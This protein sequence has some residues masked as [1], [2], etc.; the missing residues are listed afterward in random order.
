MVLVEADHSG[1]NPERAGTAI[2]DEVDPALQLVGGV[3]GVRRT[4]ASGGTTA[5][6]HAMP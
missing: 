2:Q 1:F 5:V 6:V 4:D 3:S